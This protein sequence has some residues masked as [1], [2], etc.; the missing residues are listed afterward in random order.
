MNDVTQRRKE[1]KYSRFVIHVE[2]EWY[3][4]ICIK[5]QENEHLIKGEGI[6]ER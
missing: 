2:I 5:F 1:K 4:M 3:N 6:G